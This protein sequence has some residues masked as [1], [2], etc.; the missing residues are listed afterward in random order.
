MFLFRLSLH[1]TMAWVPSRSLKMHR[2]HSNFL[3]TISIKE[4]RAKPRK[5]C[6]CWKI[7]QK[8]LESLKKFANVYVLFCV[9]K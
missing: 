6:K 5:A 8:A 9:K 2:K 3:L 1:F 7:K 4:L